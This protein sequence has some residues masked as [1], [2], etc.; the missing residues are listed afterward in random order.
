MYRSHTELDERVIL[1]MGTPALAEAMKSKASTLYV[2]AFSGATKNGASPTPAEVYNIICLYA[3]AIC[4]V[5]MGNQLRMSLQAHKFAEN[6]GFKNFTRE[7]TRLWRAN[8]EYLSGSPA[9]FHREFPGWQVCVCACVCVC[10]C[11]CV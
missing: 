4:L 3:S 11:V 10:V 7:S 5:V 1:C 8:G 9:K 2:F 6:E